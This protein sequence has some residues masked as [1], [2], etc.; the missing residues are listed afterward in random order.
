MRLLIVEDEV[1]LAE[2]LKE[3]FKSEFFSVDVAHDGERG[4]F[5]A[6]TNDYDL[7]IMDYVLPGINGAQVIKEIKKENKDLPIIMLTVK[8]ELDDKLDLFALGIDDYVSKPFIFEEL[9]A[10]VQAVLRRPKITKP[11]IF[12]IDDLIVNVDR[13]TVRRS[14]RNIRLTRKE[15]LLLEYLL[16]NRGRV[17][18]RAMILEHVWDVNADPFSNTIESHMV[19]LRRKINLPGSHDLIQT[20]AGRGYKIDTLKV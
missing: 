6:R 10:R 5:L 19:N 9:L 15:M 12:R 13:H 18:S 20:I 7:V 17:L 8:S 1:D 11:K 14:G 4:S 16:Q 2:F 3:S